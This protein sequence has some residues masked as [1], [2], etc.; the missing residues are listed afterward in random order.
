MLQVYYAK[1]TS[2]F[3]QRNVLHPEKSADRNYWL[4]VSQPTLRLPTRLWRGRAWG[5]LHMLHWVYNSRWLRMR[6]QKRT[7]NW[8]RSQCRKSISRVQLEVA[9]GWCSDGRRWRVWK[10][11]KHH[12]LSL[13]SISRRVHPS[14]RP[15]Q[16][17]C[18]GWRNLVYHQWL[19]VKYRGTGI[20]FVHSHIWWLRYIC[21]TNAKTNA[22]ANTED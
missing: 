15:H 9:S 12:C 16:F 4:Y 14:N 7:T 18:W 10:W 13:P 11:R 8:N 3:R 22:V 21:S 19:F 2:Y 5:S 17:V 6:A 20:A 1:L